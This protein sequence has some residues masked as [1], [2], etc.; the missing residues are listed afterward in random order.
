MTWLNR[1]RNEKQP[2]LDYFPSFSEAKA[3]MGPSLI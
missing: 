3:T 2:L 1:W